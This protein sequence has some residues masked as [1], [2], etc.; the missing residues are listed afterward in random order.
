MTN[1]I[2]NPSFEDGTTNWNYTTDGTGTFDAPT[3]G[4]YDGSKYGRISTTTAGVANN[5]LYQTDVP[6]LPNTDYR[7]T[8]YA[9]SSRT[10][11]ISVTLFKHGAPYTNYG[12]DGIIEIG[13]GDWAEIVYEFTTNASADVDA[14]FSI[15]TCDD[16]ADGQVDYYD[17]II[18]EQ[19][20]IPL[21]A[22]VGDSQAAN[23]NDAIQGLMSLNAQVED[24][25]NAL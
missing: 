21:T 6:L 25:I 3:G 1:I 7:L 20:I 16:D 4:A 24:D 19:V 18:I 15:N 5:Q 13:N 14:R 22:G 8:F 23:W 11:N 12:L 17:L 2:L 10:H 9:K